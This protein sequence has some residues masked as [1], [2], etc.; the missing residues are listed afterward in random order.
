MRTVSSTGWGCQR[1]KDRMWSPAV[2][3][4]PP[5]PPMV[6]GFRDPHCFT[7]TFSLSRPDLSH[8]LV[9]R[10]AF[11]SQLL[12]LLPLVC[13]QSATPRGSPPGNASLPL[14]VATHI[15]VLRVQSDGSLQKGDDKEAHRG[16]RHRALCGR[17]ERRAAYSDFVL[18][19][20]GTKARPPSKWMKRH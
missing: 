8:L 7:L 4:P 13:L 2:H 1:G 11:H 14:P 19:L 20:F 15:G 9:G 16:W 6:L 5:C 17:T 10:Q 18:Q 3:I 12:P